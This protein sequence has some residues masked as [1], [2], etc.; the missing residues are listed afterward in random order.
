MKTVL[1]VWFLASVLFP[2]FS[3]SQE[4]SISDSAR[5]V[6]QSRIDSINQMI[7]EKGYR[8]TAGITSKSY[9][10]KEEM[11][12]LC[13]LQR[14]TSKLQAM[15]REEDSLYQQYKETNLKNQKLFKTP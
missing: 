2:R 5:A 7:K 6:V 3:F 10:T 9:L 12:S 4:G 15:L 13:G 11:A 8:W 14:D 1:C